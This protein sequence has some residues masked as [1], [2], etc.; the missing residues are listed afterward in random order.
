MASRAERRNWASIALLT[1]PLIVMAGSAV[2]WLS[3]S[4]DE[5]VWFAALQKPFLMPPTWVFGF[6]WTVLYILMGVAV[7]LIL[8]EPPSPR[9]RN[10]LILFFAQLALNF[11]WSPVFFVAHDI[12]L[13]KYL[14]YVM[15]VVAAAAAGQFY[16]LRKAAGLL[17]IPYL[18]WLIFISVLNSMIESLNP[19]ARMAL[20]G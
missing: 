2:G 7:A 9:R 11:A 3:D 10:A 8:A 14:I 5:N 1:A 19:G 15:A 12:T 4:G 13:A 6:A 18:A 20:L 17:M 16:R